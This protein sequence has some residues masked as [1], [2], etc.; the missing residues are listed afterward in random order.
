M[1][2]VLVLVTAVVATVKF[3]VVLPAFT[4]TV[5][6]TV[7]AALLLESATTAPPAGAAVVRV[8]VPVEGVPPTTLGGLRDTL[9][10]DRVG[11]TKSVVFSVSP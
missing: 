2:T 9:R 8:T 4:V 10:S 5:A 7:A 1:V 11:I 6:G 3:A